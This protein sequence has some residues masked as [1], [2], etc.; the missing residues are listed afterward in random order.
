MLDAMRQHFPWADSAFSLR[1]MTDRVAVTR[2]IDA[3]SEGI[4]RDFCSKNLSKYLVLVPDAS[5]AVYVQ[6]ETS[7]WRGGTYGEIPVVAGAV[8]Q[9]VRYNKVSDA[10]WA[11]RKEQHVI[12]LNALKRRRKEYREDVLQELIDSDYDEELGFD[13]SLELLRG[14]VTRTRRIPVFRDMRGGKEYAIDLYGTCTDDGHQIVRI[15]HAYLHVVVA[16]PWSTGWKTKG[17]RSKIAAI[18]LAHPGTP[19]RAMTLVDKAAPKDSNVLIRGEAKNLGPKVP[20][21]F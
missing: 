11:K 21:R 10:E 6:D 15:G 8:L 7:R 19:V 5:Y 18:E 12:Q 2:A 3:R 9:F 17:G 4:C 20:R 1:E 14:H 13:D 16:T